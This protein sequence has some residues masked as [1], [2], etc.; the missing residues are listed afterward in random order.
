M[1]IISTSLR[2]IVLQTQREYNEDILTKV[3]IA[4]TFYTVAILIFNNYYTVL[5]SQEQKYIFYPSCV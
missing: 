3:G 5:V 2:E 1:A 4:V